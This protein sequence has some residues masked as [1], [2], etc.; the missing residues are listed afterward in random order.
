MDHI[1]RKLP[2]SDHQRTV[3]VPGG[4]EFII[5]PNQIV[6]WISLTS[7]DQLAIATDTPRFP[8]LVD[9]GLSHNFSIPCLGMRAARLNRLLLRI[10]SSKLRLSIA[11]MTVP[12]VTDSRSAVVT[13]HRDSWA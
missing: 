3:A 6:I 2:Y 11:R 1:I 9:T 4:T 8:V 12:D 5:R 7:V 10:D 13:D